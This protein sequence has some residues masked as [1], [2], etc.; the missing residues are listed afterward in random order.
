MAPAAVLAT[1]T[2]GPHIVYVGGNLGSGK[3]TLA[4]AL[5]S[6]DRWR[7]VREHEPPLDYLPDLFAEPARWAL[8][9]QV[10]FLASKAETVRSLRGDVGRSFAVVD[11]SVYEHFEVFVR[12]FHEIGAIDDRGLRMFARLH[13]QMIH[14]LPRPA[15][16]LLCDAAA[17]V[18]EDRI[19]RRGRDVD[20]LYPKG[21]IARLGRHL[22]AWACDFR[23]APLLILDSVAHD[24]RDAATARRIREDIEAVV[25]RRDFRTDI[26]RVQFP[27]AR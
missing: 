21:H 18:C 16:V 27:Q 19:R 26:L 15:A 3:S 7:L 20:R 22:S 17:D 11:R 8:E 9:T 1:P 24:P 6:G 12:A 2:P 25:L 13:A 14:G 10:A 23:D 5:S 4:Q